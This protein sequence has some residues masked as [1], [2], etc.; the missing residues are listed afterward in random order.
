MERDVDRNDVG[1]TVGM[2]NLERWS[3]LLLTISFMLYGCMFK[4]CPNDKL[5]V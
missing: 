2:R 1:L 5:R 4:L 3:L